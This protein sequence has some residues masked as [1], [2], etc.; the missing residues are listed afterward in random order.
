VAWIAGGQVLGTVIPSSSAAPVPAVGLGGAGG[1]SGLAVDMS[2]NGVAY[3]V[4]SEPG[5][6]GADVRAARLQGTAW[7]PVAAP[8]D[9]DPARSAGSGASRPR[10]GVGAEN[11]AVVTWG[12]AGGDGRNHVYSR[13]LIGLALS[14]F[15]QDL[16]LDTFENQAAGSADSPDLDIQ[17]DGS[18]AWVAFRQDVGGR[19]RSVARR[20]RG[21]L[22]DAPV[23]IDGGATSS[24]PRIDFTPGGIG[25]AV[26]A[27]SDNA[28]FSAYLDK[29]DT[30]QPAVRIDQTPSGTHPTPVVA[31]SGREDAYAAWRTGAGDGSGAVHARRKDGEGAFGPEFTA[32]N[33]SFGAVAPGQVAIGV[34]RAGNAAVAMVQGAPPARRLTVA[35]HDLFPGSPS[36]R[37]RNA[38]RGRRPIVSWSPGTEDWGS[39]V[40][41]LLIDGKPAGTTSRRRITSTRSV[42]GRGVHRMQVLATDIRGQTSRSRTYRFRVDAVAP[43]LSAS[44]RRSGRLVRVATRARDRGRSGL[45]RVV[46]DFGDGTRTRSTSASHRYGGFRLA[47]ADR[48]ARGAAA[49]APDGALA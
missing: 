49:T 29:F 14:A 21:T 35:V 13:R 19:S 1:A 43:M 5:G 12:E 18:F 22:F 46:I 31:T 32:S 17:D 30:F 45:R 25:A 9:I 42:G 36:I 8:L 7:S 34:D 16:T 28:T 37:P 44:A 11:N 38:Y 40:F 23:A 2:A 10:V 24:A 3:A 47:S 26:T 27:A 48:G 15:P 39:Q 6:G 33:P 20:L 4:W 41:T